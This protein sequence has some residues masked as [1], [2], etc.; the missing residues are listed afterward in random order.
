MYFT[1]C[2]YTLLS[3]L[4]YFYAIV[5][6]LKT[7]KTVAMMGVGGAIFPGA[8]SD[9]RFE[10]VASFFQFLLLITPKSMDLCGSKLWQV[11]TRSLSIM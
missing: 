5:N 2:N 3:I 6:E 1:T 4:V 7:C 8:P 10:I 9:A 11:L